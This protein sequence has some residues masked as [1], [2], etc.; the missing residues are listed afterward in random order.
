MLQ[1][2]PHLVEATDASGGTA[3]HLAARAGRAGCAAVL[4]RAGAH[5]DAADADGWSPLRAAA[6]AGHTEVGANN[7]RIWL[8]NQKNVLESKEIYRL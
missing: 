7:T 3:L 5:P 4:L 1:R 6:W 8:E 2:H